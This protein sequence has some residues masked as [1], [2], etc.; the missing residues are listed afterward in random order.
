M[1]G[2]DAGWVVDLWKTRGCCHAD[3]KMRVGIENR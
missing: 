1:F 2:V 3:A